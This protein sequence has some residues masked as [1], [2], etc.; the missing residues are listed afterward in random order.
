MTGNS[1]LYK[2]KNSVGSTLLIIRGLYI[3]RAKHSFFQLKCSTNSRTI[4]FTKNFLEECKKLEGKIPRHGNRIFDAQPSDATGKHAIEHSAEIEKQSQCAP[5]LDHALQLA[6]A[7][8][9]V[10]LGASHI[11]QLC[12]QIFLQLLIGCLYFT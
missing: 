4:P 2:N 12:A 9:P 7:G 8:L 5:F 10:L 1:F 3:H 6:L 11:L